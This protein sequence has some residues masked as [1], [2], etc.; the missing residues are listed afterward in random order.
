MFEL[1]R[2]DIR[3]KTLGFGIRPEDQTFFRKRVTP[4]LEFGTFGVMVYRF[5]SWAYTVKIPVIRQLLILTYL[6]VN[7]F[8]MAVTGIHIARETKIGPGL[9]IH[10]FSGILVLADEIGHSCTLNQQV[11]IMNARGVGR[12]TIGNNCYFGAGCKVVGKVKIGD[13]VVVSAN[14]LVVMDVP[15]NS[16]VLGVPARIISREA[17]SPYLKN[18][19]IPMPVETPAPAPTA[20]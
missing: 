11:S 4:F 13:N 3:R 2:D 20:S 12:A 15:S 6:F 9:V 19:I 18:P 17:N 1:I 5:G 14:S 7:V 16:T 10:N 8:C